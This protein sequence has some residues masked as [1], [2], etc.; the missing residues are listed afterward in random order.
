[1]K[2]RLLLFMGMLGVVNLLT[3]SEA[4]GASGKKLFFERDFNG[5]GQTCG[6]CHREDD[7]QLMAF[8]PGFAEDLFACDPN[9]P[10]FVLLNS[11]DAESGDFSRMFADGTIPIPR[12]VPANV[13]VI[14]VTPDAIVHYD[15]EGKAFIYVHRKT[16][17]ILN[18][19]LKSELMLDGREGQDLERQALN[20]AQTHFGPDHVPPTPQQ[21]AKL[22][23]FQEKQFSD[24]AM[25]KL[26]K[27][28][29]LRKLPAAHGPLEKVGK[30][31]L[32]P[33]GKCYQCHGGPNLDETSDDNVVNSFINTFVMPGA[34]PSGQHFSTNFSGSNVVHSQ[35]SGAPAHEFGNPIF[36][37]VIHNVDENG[38]SAPDEFGVL[39]RTMFGSD[40][41]AIF[42]LDANGNARSCQSDLS[43]CFV[44]GLFGDFL[45][46]SFVIPSLWDIGDKLAAGH[47]FFH[48]GQAHNFEQVLEVY[49]DLFE[50]TKLGMG[51]LT[52][53]PGNFENL[54]LTQEEIEG[55]ILYMTKRMRSDN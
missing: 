45:R 15:D 26:A 7:N 3:I 18:I 44:N 6:T 22:A 55:T 28:G 51:L 25:K 8:G 48:H 14:P 27:N 47:T 41:G 52:G 29:K 43:N 11:A 1:M 9:D 32:S 16:P 31:M 4:Q 19:A 34:L 35:L 50:Q 37:F 10:L 24:P 54:S 53:N 20:A 49:V 13:E 39:T 46:E 12:Y 36:M 42:N 23:K 17:S 40:P 33:G 21:Q 30:A 38:D 5:N 2:I